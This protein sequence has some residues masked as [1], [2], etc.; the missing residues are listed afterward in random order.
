[1][2]ELSLNILDI[3]ENSAKAGASRIGISLFENDQTLTI[4][5]NDNG[6]GM[7]RETLA[8]VE[9]PFFTTRTTRKVGLGIPFFKEE[10]LQTGGTFSVTS[11]QQSEDPL[12]HGTCV[13]AVFRK[14]HIDFTPLG[15][16]VATLVTLIQ[17]HPDLDFDFSHEMPDGKVTLDTADMRNMLEGVSL[18]QPEV[19]LWAREYLQEQYQQIYSERK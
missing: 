1:M 11:R 15:D 7:S 16:I 6:C 4:E 19:L 14:D 8:G 9:N 18:A 5:I 3:A 2:K 17:G 10:A 13:R 12:H